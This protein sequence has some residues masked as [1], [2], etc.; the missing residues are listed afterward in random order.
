MMSIVLVH[1][2]RNDGV[3]GVRQS[4]DRRF[5]RNVCHVPR[6]IPTRNRDCQFCV[7]KEVHRRSCNTCLMGVGIYSTSRSAEPSAS[8]IQNEWFAGAP[9]DGH[10]RRGASSWPCGIIRA[11]VTAP[12]CSG[13]SGSAGFQLGP[14]RV[15]LQHPGHI[16]RGFICGLFPARSASTVK[17][18]CA[19][20]KFRPAGAPKAQACQLFASTSRVTPKR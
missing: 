1:V 7:C 10:S 11:P 15:E 6:L 5:G 13:Y 17:A 19:R 9:D 14:D 4:W 20:V 12:K 2:I 8:A 3:D 16:S 18:S